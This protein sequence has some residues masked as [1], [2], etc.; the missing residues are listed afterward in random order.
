VLILDLRTV[1]DFRDY[2]GDPSKN[3]HNNTRIKPAL[4]SVL[5]RLG[6]ATQLT[7]AVIFCQRDLLLICVGPPAQFSPC[8]KPA[9]R[10]L[11]RSCAPDEDL[12]VE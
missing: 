4:S 2:S 5:D 12:L 6:Q 3:L 7:Q 1:L 10:P 9:N 8:L 11:K